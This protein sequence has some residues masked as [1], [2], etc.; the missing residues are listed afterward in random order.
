MG[1]PL[2]GVLASAITAGLATVLQAMAV[3]RVPLV[4]G[5]RS[6][7]FGAL[8]RS[9]LYLSALGLVLA[10]FVITAAVLQ[11]LPVFIVQAGR[12][13]SLAVTA[14]LSVVLLNHRLT[15]LEVGALVGVCVG[16][17]TLALCTP[18]GSAVDASTAVRLGLLAA[19]AV[20]VV[21]AVLAIRLPVGR[22]SGAVLA[23]VAGLAFAVPPVAARGIG[24]WG[25]AD[26]IA[27]P[28]AWALGVSALIG[29]GASALA[30]QRTS[31]VLA[32][33]LVVSVETVL[34]AALGVALYGDEPADGR[35]GLA[36]L[37][38]AITLG[39]SM[40]LARFGAPQEQALALSADTATPTDRP[41]ARTAKAHPPRR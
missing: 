33:C 41:P 34:S 10:G 20:L 3:R 27:D 7:S 17:A 15:R 39:S 16:L 29:L 12:A 4:R 25:P 6:P 30:L 23:L 24:S 22:G 1:L 9:P 26:L 18:K 13:S 40:A 21:I 35:W 36:V 28:A 32:T 5:L 31:V 38:V 11:S 37:G 14:V 2:I 8:L 19:A